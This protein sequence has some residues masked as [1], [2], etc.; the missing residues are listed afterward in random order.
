M[1]GLTGG[2]WK[3]SDLATVTAVK[4]PAGE[5]RGKL[6]AG[7]NVR[8]RHRASPR[9]YVTATRSDDRA[10]ADSERRWSLA[11]WLCWLT[12]SER[13]W[14]WWNAEVGRDGTLRATVEV[15][16]WPTALGALDCLLRAAG[17]ADDRAVAWRLAVGLCVMFI[18]APATRWGYFAYPLGLLGWLGLT[19]RDWAAAGRLP[20]AG[21]PPQPAPSG[22][23]WRRDI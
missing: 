7:P 12:L 1:H 18:L 17:A 20:A 22:C 8:Q 9:P 11:D 6:A 2:G 4:R 19:G 23:L 3:R 5:T 14:F 15:A 21:A 16:R 13:L 10:R